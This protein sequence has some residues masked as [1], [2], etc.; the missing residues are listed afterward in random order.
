MQ[1]QARAQLQETKNAQR[2]VEGVKKVDTIMRGKRTEQQPREGIEITR[3]PIGVH[4]HAALVAGT[5][6]D[7]GVRP[8]PVTM[9]IPEV[10][11]IRD[12]HVVVQDG[13]ALEQDR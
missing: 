6:E 3:L 12:Q 1:A 8:G 10:A 9:E 13:T 5:P 7:Q 2:E 4:G 11:E